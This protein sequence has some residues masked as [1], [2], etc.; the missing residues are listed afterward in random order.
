MVKKPLRIREGSIVTCVPSIPLD[1]RKLTILF[2]FSS[3]IQ[4][5]VRSLVTLILVEVVLKK[6]IGAISML[7]R[8]LRS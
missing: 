5:V 8:N 2:S 7:S 6:N 1:P 3:G 4:I